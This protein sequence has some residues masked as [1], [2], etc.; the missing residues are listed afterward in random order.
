MAQQ[1]PTS[2]RDRSSID[3]LSEEIEWKKVKMENLFQI[4][5]EDFEIEKNK[6]KNNSRKKRQ[7]QPSAWCRGKS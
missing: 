2:Q 4:K 5:G 6:N 1:P 7:N 3:Q